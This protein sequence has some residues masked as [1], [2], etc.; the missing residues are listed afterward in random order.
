MGMIKKMKELQIKVIFKTDL[1]KELKLV[2]NE[3]KR[4]LC[5]L[6][7]KHYKDNWLRVSYYQTLRT[8]DIQENIKSN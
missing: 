3:L 8:F 7:E 5:A 4:D 1:D 2:T 6:L